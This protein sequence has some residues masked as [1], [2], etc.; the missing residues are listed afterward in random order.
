MNS[1]VKSAWLWAAG[2]ALLVFAARVLE[3]RTHGSAV[4]L[5]DQWF[6]EGAQILLPWFEGTLRLSDF[7]RPHYEHLPL[8]TRLLVWLQVVLTGRWDPLVQITVNAA[9]H[10]AFV[11]VV[12][13]WIACSLGRAET[14]FCTLVLI[15]LSA[16][17]H[18]WENI[19]WGFQSQFPLAL[20]ALVLL[21]RGSFVHATGSRAWWLAQAIGIAGLFTLG[22]MALA[23]LAVVLVVLWTEPRSKQEWS[24]PA[25]VGATGLLLACVLR[26]HAQVPLAA[27]AEHSPLRL[28]HATLDLLGWP[29]AWPGGA[30]LI[31]LPLMLLGLQLRGRADASPLDRGVLSLGV[32]SLGQA[33]ALAYARGGDYSGYISRYGDLLAVGVLANAVALVRLAPRHGFG[34]GV[35]LVFA[36]AWTGA[37]GISLH[38]LTTTAHTQYFHERSAMWHEQR[39][40]AVRTFVQTGDRSALETPAMRAILFGTPDVVARVLSH[41]RIQEALAP[42][43][44]PA[45]RLSWIG[46]TVRTV[47]ALAWVPAFLGLLGLAS[48]LAHRSPVA[49]LPPWV[50]QRDP[51]AAPVC[52][53]LAIAAAAALT[54]WPAPRT[55]DRTARWE[56]F[57]NP[58]DVVR[59]VEFD[60]EGNAPMSRDRIWGAAEISPPEYR[61]WFAGTRPDPTVTT[62]IL[63]STPFTLTA[64]RL[65][66]PVAG[67]PAAVGNALRVE[68]L[69]E[70]GVVIDQRTFA[71]DNPRD[72]HFWTLDLSAHV[73]QQV[74]IILEDGR[75]GTQD[76]LAVGPPVLT[77]R[78]ERADE[79]DKGLALERLAQTHATLGWISLASGV[80]ALAFVFTARRQRTED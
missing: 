10:A 59:D 51:V 41:P 53:A 79:L 18:A 33:L 7:F 37:L 38:R 56:L 28:L 76:W 63:K 34:A 52:A 9:F 2:A 72:V 27:N 3:I 17:P 31:N 46:R 8:W 64:P 67:F 60:F 22:S 12:A 58:T 75:E 47:H 61:N 45:N 26:I 70:T 54:I 4:P 62:A 42:E 74:R 50:W 73:G 5:N 16:A 49:P 1:S 24:V 78:V 77:D 65:I 32:W 11:G 48:A 71:G 19:T 6:V 57:L 15:A 36:V 30:M 80:L 44:N 25:L 43:V 23:P 35:A 69:A 66:L 13:H 39:S 68:L 55:F 20:L 14:I 29:T 21:V 40:A